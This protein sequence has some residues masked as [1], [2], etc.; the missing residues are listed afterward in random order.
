MSTGMH[1]LHCPSDVGG[2]PWGL[3]RAER[4][5]GLQSDMVVFNQQWFGYNNDINLN[6]NA[7]PILIKDF[8]RFKF[9]RSAL[10][11][12]D[13]F[14]FNFGRS[15]LDYPFSGIFNYI[16]LPS[17]KRK[18][19]K[20]VMTFQGCDARIKH[21]CCE[22]FDISA[23]AECKVWYCNRVTDAMK[24]RRLAKISKYA[25]N[26]FVLNPDLKHFLPDAEFLP[27]ASIDLKQWRPAGTSPPPEVDDPLTILH[28]P[29]NRSIKGTEHII[30]A[31]TEL[32][33]EGYPVRLTLAEN[34][35]HARMKAVY[36]S[37]DIFVDQLLVGWYGAAA[38]EAMSLGKPSV[39][40][41]RESD[42][43]WLSFKD[44][45]PVINAT[46]DTIYDT[47]LHFIK[48]RH[49]LKEIGL[50]SRAY[51]EEVHDPAKIAMQLKRT[52]ES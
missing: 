49:R 5:L 19:K 10:D 27:Y 37:A 13:V 52:Y 8:K 42:L 23:C 31:C 44:S 22:N 25:D 6:L 1:I 11:K 26:V 14:H 47:L 20:V 45:I 15:I 3:S 50:R 38:V 21:Y 2:N 16:D 48:D 51:V 46:C 12:Y 18:G 32:E 43:S 30:Q 36:E 34:I 24:E 40:Y 29:S 33:R 17:L 35:P 41:L 39:C 9:Y 28:A 4:A 7:S